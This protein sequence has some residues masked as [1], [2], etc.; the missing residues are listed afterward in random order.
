[1]PGLKVWRQKEAFSMMLIQR[2]LPKHD[3]FEK[4]NREND[5][6]DDYVA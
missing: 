4:G 3:S 1:M 5:T 2:M 6:S